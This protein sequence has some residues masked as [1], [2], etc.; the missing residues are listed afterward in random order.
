MNERGESEA[1]EPYTVE[2]I[3]QA[4]DAHA[5]E[6][7]WGVPSF[8]EEGLIAALR[9]AYGCRHRFPDGT[10]CTLD[11]DAHAEVPG[12]AEIHGYRV[13]PARVTSK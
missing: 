11:A 4:F 2:Q 10:R 6:D 1:A 13:T 12:L 3:R 8:Y 5:N 7:S 9:G